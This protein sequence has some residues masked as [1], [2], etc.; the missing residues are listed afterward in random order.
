MHL[1]MIS[2]LHDCLGNEA[3][4]IGVFFAKYGTSGNN[5]GTSGEGCETSGETFGAS[6]NVLKD[7]TT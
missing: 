3:R 6:A 4:D 2:D 5:F 1:A 7:H